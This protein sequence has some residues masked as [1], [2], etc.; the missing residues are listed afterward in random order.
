MQYQPSS[1]QFFS[2]WS[3]KMVIAQWVLWVRCWIGDCYKPPLSRP[4]SGRIPQNDD[5]KMEGENAGVYCEWQWLLWKIYCGAWRWRWW[6]IIFFFTSRTHFFTFVR[7]RRMLF[8]SN[9][10]ILAMKRATMFRLHSIDR[11]LNEVSYSF[12]FSPL[13][14]A[15]SPFSG[16]N[17]P[18]KYGENA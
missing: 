5:C 16:T 4:S 8:S 1:L 13:D 17:A 15:V 2:F 11:K 7:C 10:C 14:S 18:L 12:F 9:V 6:R 3:L